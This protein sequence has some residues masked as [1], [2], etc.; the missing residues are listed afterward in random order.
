[1]SVI[2][3]VHRIVVFGRVGWVCI[4]NLQVVSMSRSWL[5]GSWLNVMRRCTLG[6]GPRV[7]RMWVVAR[8]K[9]LL[10]VVSAVG[11]E[12]GRTD[13]AVKL[14]ARGPLYFV[15]GVLSWVCPRS[16]HSHRH[17]SEHSVGR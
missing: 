2:L 7:R 4:A 1:M 6:V 8:M 15:E 14:E 16:Y 5:I 11:P 12:G 9:P 13:C 17:V 3:G 10:K